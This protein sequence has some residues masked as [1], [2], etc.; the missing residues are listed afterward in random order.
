MIYLQYKTFSG[1]IFFYKI[2]CK[3]N[4]CKGTFQ[5]YINNMF[6]IIMQLF[7][8]ASWR[9][10]DKCESEIKFYSLLQIAE[11]PYK[12]HCP[13]PIHLFTF[14]QYITNNSLQMKLS[15]EKLLKNNQWVYFCLY[16]KFVWLTWLDPLQSGQHQHR[17][18]RWI[19]S[20]SCLEKGYTWAW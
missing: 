10:S 7:H 4:L 2:A 5:M 8:F 6:A 1:L 13:H 18:R 3:I 20:E 16:F 17:R 11:H 14:F 12:H 15:V 9:I 19:Q